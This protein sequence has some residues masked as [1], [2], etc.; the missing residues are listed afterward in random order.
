MFCRTCG[1]QIVDDAKFCPKCGTQTVAQSPAKEPHHISDSEEAPLMTPPFVTPPYVPATPIAFTTNMVPVKQHFYKSFGNPLVLISGIFLLLM[2]ILSWEKIG[3]WLENIDNY[4]A[5]YIARLLFSPSDGDIIDF[6]DGFM[7]FLYFFMYF[8]YALLGFALLITAIGG[9]IKTKGVIK[10]G[11]VSGIIACTS[12]LLFGAIFFIDDFFYL[13]YLIEEN[14]LEYM[15]DVDYFTLFLYFST[16]LFAVLWEIG[17]IIFFANA[18]KTINRVNTPTPCLTRL[19]GILAAVGLIGRLVFASARWAVLIVLE[20]Y[21]LD[22]FTIS[23]YMLEFTILFSIITLFVTRSMA[24]RALNS[25]P[26]VGS[27]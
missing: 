18:I 27:Y 3:Y 13:G 8:G 23:Y 5:S 15:S 16:H 7:S 14:L 26:V 9:C 4:N 25:Q 21:S 17:G 19:G 6:M 2:L 1:A 20:D 22:T 12:L 24:N 11:L 10:F